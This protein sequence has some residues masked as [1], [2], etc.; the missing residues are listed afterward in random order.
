VNAHMLARRAYSNSASSTRTA[1]SAEYEIIAKITHQLR[2]SA[3]RG[4]AG[5]AEMAS[6]LHN[7]RK[8][9]TALAVDVA[10][11]DNQLPASLRAQII[12]LAEFTHRYTGT[13]L[14]EKASVAPLLQINAAV[15]KGLR[16]EGSQR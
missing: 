14:K 12:Y 1:R 7:N 6:A 2:A 4:R 10:A 9:W 5:F 16:N 3:L 13:V 11:A 15:L 8:L